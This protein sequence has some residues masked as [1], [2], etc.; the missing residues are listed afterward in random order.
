MV[1]PKILQVVGYQNSGKTT[2]V[3]QLVQALTEKDFN[4]ATIKHHGHGEPDVVTNKDSSRHIVSGA[5]TTI[6]EGEGMLL[7]QAKKHIWTLEEQIQILTFMKPDVI[8]IEGHKK[9]NYPKVLLLR[10]ENDQCLIEQ[11]SNI[12]YTVAKEENNEWVIKEIVNKLIR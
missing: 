6:V 1:T 7:M 11:L 4:V 12:K 3:T 5:S 10:D 8:I 9:A 2:F